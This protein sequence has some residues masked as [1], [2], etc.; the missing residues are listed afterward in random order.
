VIAEGYATGVG[1]PLPHLLRRF[2]IA[3]A[4]G[5]A[6]A[7]LM[8]A[9]VLC[10][11]LT[12]M[13]AFEGLAR[14]GS[15]M[16]ANTAVCI[17]LLAIGF[18]LR[19]LHGRRGCLAARLSGAAV[20]A[21]AGMTL[22]ERLLG[23]S[24][25]I[26][27]F[28]ARDAHTAIDPGRMSLQ[29]AASVVLLGVVLLL[30]GQGRVQRSVRGW[31][32][33]AA[34][35]LP[36]LGLIGY[37]SGTQS[38]YHLPN[39]AQ[40]ALSSVVSLL[41]LTWAAVEPRLEKDALRLLT[42]DSIG[43]RV[44]RRLIPATVGIPLG[45]G[46]L[47]RLGEAQ[48]VFNTEVGLMLMIASA[49]ILLTAFAWATAR[50]LDDLD[51]A[52]GTAENALRWERDRFVALIDAQH[53][54]VAVISNAGVLENVNPAFCRITGFG[55]DELVGHNA[56]YPF[57]HENDP[58]PLLGY[59][60]LPRWEGAAEKDVL[61]RR[62]DG[63]TVPVI[64]AGSGVRDAAGGP[65]EYILTIKDVSERQ[66]VED[67][68]HKGEERIAALL[69][70]A[71]DAVVI[72]DTAGRINLVNTQTERLFGYA[73][74]ELVGGTIDRLLPERM[75]GDH[76]RHRAAYAADPRPRQMG[77]GMDL[78]GRRRDG[79][80]F[81]VDISLST[82]DTDDGLLLTAFIR[83]V[84]VLREHQV[85][86][87]RLLAELALRADDLARSNAE[88]EQF[89]YI[90]SHDLAE[91]LRSI[92]GFTQLLAR[93]YEGQ[94][95]ADADRFIGFVVDGVDR[96]QM[97]ISD[98]L[99][100]SRTGRAE[101]DRTQVALGQ[102]SVDVLAALSPAIADAGGSVTVGELPTVDAD[103]TKMTQLLQNLISNALKFHPPER[104]PTV[105]VTA[106]RVGADWRISVSDTG[107]GIDPAYA[108]RIFK[109]F[110]RL[111]GREE[112]PGTGIGLAVCQRIVERHGGRLWFEPNAPHGT[113]F[114]FTLPAGSAD[115]PGGLAA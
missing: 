32:A 17:V 83:D 69:E 33:I 63:G 85:E 62:R 21:V 7:G 81:P 5:T 11:W 99:A 49:V 98:L 40:I 47:R 115:A 87:E 60:G 79:T 20:V 102:V 50:L 48:G 82:L 30:T 27:Q 91:P 77:V 23:V 34:A 14:G 70:S 36:A 97:L 53:D 75:R 12:D 9:I 111:H 107:L 29:A 78:V 38:L 106:D 66:R 105:A 37:A 41:L 19:A 54:G 4:L 56:P 52:R 26:D 84:T 80:E 22:V 55:R 88:L 1:R 65:V 13:P 39:Q 64:A 6:L 95:D 94:L 103:P 92:S 61:L 44:A 10:G 76:G 113:I 93:R 57:L 100:F 24:A 31:L 109:M 51:N 46:L 25:G 74:D 110:Q 101:L 43:G 42:L 90:A 45:L 73:K 18:R 89:A 72:V 15:T 112:F 104:P 114:R 96:M 16:K 67:A 8:G 108:E 28:I 35:I 58:I 59:I 2:E 86:R 71:P 68:R 3:A